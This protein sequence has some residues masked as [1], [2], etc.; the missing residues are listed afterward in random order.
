MNLNGLINGASIASKVG[1][2]LFI[3]SLFVWCHFWTPE[4][5]YFVLKSRHGHLAGLFLYEAYSGMLRMSKNYIFELLRSLQMKL[6]LHRS[7]Y[8]IDTDSS[9]SVMSMNRPPKSPV[10]ILSP[11]SSLFAY[12]FV[13]VFRQDLIPRPLER[14]RIAP[15]SVVTIFECAIDERATLRV[16]RVEMFMSLPWVHVVQVIGFIMT[17]Y[18]VSVGTK[19]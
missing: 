16:L 5:G 10:S 18:S 17:S 1:I 3:G 13:L 2:F 6:V 19:S 8:Y 14:Q 11:I 7:R 12:F 9:P 15:H 4:A